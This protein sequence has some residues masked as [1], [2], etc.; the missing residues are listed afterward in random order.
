MPKRSVIL[1]IAASLDGYI[2]TADHQLDWLF[3]VAG[4]G[5]N[6][7]AAF[8]DTIDTILMGRTTD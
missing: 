1:F 7:I 5:D 2:A 6:D 3:E 4:E 8:S